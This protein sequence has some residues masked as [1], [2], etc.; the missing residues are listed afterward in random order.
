MID[1]GKGSDVRFDARRNAGGLLDEIAERALD[2]DY[3]L[4]RPGRYSRSREFTSYGTAMMIA[5]FALMI[6]VTA[7]QTQRDRPATAL[8]RQALESDVTAS[9]DQLAA[10][11]DLVNDLAAQ[12]ELLE[13]V[14][15]T[16]SP[17][18]LRLHVRAGDTAVTGP[19]IVV[20]LDPKDID[21]DDTA[22]QGIVNALW[23][24]GA[25]AISL[26]GQRISGLTSIGE[27]G[28]VITVNFRSIGAPFV[29]RAIGESDTLLARFDG[30]SAAQYWASR[31]ASHEVEFSSAAE[32]K[33]ALPAGAE[34]RTTVR[35]AEVVKES[36]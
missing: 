5:F 31:S 7:V 2:D 28:G 35:V 10:K 20:R 19:G 1:L 16:G 26:N 12:V 4:V 8:E 36:R 13:S 22:L 27:G 14:T 3:Y 33:L 24:A 11:Q 18:S 25:E 32:D 15:D 9:R 29:F 6:T 30:A 17:A 21:I 23:A 34:S